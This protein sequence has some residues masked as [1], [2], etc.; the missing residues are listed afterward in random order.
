ML[1]EWMARA[2]FF[3]KGKRRVEVDEELQ[4]RMDRQI[5]SNL[6]AGMAQ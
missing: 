5:E 6:T 4:F 3:L 1:S 2:R